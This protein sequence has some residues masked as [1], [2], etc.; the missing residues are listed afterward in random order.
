[1]AEV[2]RVYSDEGML[3]KSYERRRQRVNR[4]RAKGDALTH[5]RLAEMAH[6]WHPEGRPVRRN[7]VTNWLNRRDPSPDWFRRMLDEVLAEAEG[8]G[9]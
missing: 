9:H 4:G 8:E 2:K 3:P 6:H 5:R 1:M 7:V